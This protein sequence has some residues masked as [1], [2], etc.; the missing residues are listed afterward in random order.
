MNG[1]QWAE[2]VINS[3]YEDKDKRIVL[4][5]IGKDVA[6]NS[7]VSTTMETAKHVIDLLKSGKKIVTTRK[8]AGTYVEGAVVSYYTDSNGIEYLRSIPNG[9]DADNLENLPKF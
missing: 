3:V 1:I 8:I 2:Y 9:Y 6:S 4:V 5:K 7:D